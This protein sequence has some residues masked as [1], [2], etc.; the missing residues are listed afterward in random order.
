MPWEQGAPALTWENLDRPR[1]LD[2]NGPYM[3]TVG[4]EIAEVGR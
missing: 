1:C 4:M 2:R 3:W